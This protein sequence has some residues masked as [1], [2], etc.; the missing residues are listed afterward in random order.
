MLGLQLGTP[1]AR[2][3][4]SLNTE[5]EKQRQKRLERSGKVVALRSLRTVTD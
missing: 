3:A 1:S 5:R 4:A 2:R